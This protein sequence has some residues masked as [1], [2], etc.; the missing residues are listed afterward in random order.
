MEILNIAL[1]LTVLNANSIF[2]T[3]YGYWWRLRKFNYT[4][5][6]SASPRHHTV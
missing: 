2:T 3:I 4:P 5:M 1:Y 6:F